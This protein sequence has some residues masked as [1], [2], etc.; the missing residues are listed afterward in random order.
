MTKEDS[1][2]KPEDGNSCRRGGSGKGD[3]QKKWEVE[4]AQPLLF[5]EKGSVDCPR[6]YNCEVSYVILC[7]LVGGG[8]G[9][10]GEGGGGGGGAGGGALP[11][12]TCRPR[13]PGNYPPSLPRPRPPL[14]TATMYRA[15]QC[16]MPCQG[17]QGAP[18]LS[19]HHSPGCVTIVQGLSL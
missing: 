19:T 2:R 15:L 18:S 16:L 1:I 5:E 12:T 3:D 17:D 8:G 9:G 6:K 13:T 7:T 10:R 14:Y 4:I 11:V